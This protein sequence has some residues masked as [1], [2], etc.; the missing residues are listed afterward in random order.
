MDS[1][2]QNQK[3]LFESLLFEVNMTEKLYY[4]DSHLY[5]FSAE[6]LFAV[7]NDDFTDIVLDATAFFPEGG[8]QKSDTGRINDLRVEYVYEKNDTIYHR[9]R[10]QANFTKGDIVECCLDSEIRFMR[11]Q[12]HS[13]EHLLSGVVHSLFDADNVGFHFDNGYVM[14]VDF[15]RYLNKVQLA[16]AEVKANEYIYKNLPVISRIYCKDELENSEFRSKL[17]FPGEARIV[18]ILGVDKCACCAPHVNYTGEI[19]LIKILTSQSHRGGVRLT[20]ICGKAAYDDYSSKYIQTMNIAAQLCA[21]HS[22]TDLAVRNLLESNNSLHYELNQLQRK[23]ISALIKQ[24]PHARVSIEFVDDISIQHLREFT[25]KLG[26]KSDIAAF[27]FI[28]NDDEGY[29]YCIYSV[30]LPL[31]D[32]IKEFNNELVGTGGGRGSMAQ[33]KVKA[34]ENKIREYIERVLGK[35]T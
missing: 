12:A 30:S 4:V 6:F 27:C 11:M 34:S 22:E 20:L 24:L 23:Y 21:K 18:E 15:N 7:E 16:E 28:G 8:G 2:A 3:R 32:F 31:S 14:T 19:G 1:G 33:G 10:G 25:E 9:V 17:D 5:E 26:Q 13:G 29:S 35:L